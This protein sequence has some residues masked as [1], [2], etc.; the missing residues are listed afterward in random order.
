MRLI[1]VAGMYSTNWHMTR[2][3]SRAKGQL[4]TV[5]RRGGHVSRRR[6]QPPTGFQRRLPL[7]V[8]EESKMADA[9]EPFGQHVQQESLQ[10]PDVMYDHTHMLTES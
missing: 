1:R 9:H 5:I 2:F 3:A 8:G 7:T 4:H 6:K 10:L